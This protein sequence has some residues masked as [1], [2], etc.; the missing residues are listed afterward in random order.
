MITKDM[1]IESIFS[2]FPGKSQK[3]AQAI[4]A[5]GL[6]CVGCQ[7]S[8]WETLEAGMLGHGF[9]DQDVESLLAKLNSI[10]SEKEDLSSISM[11]E[12]AVKKFQEILKDDGREKTGLRFGIRAG[13][14]SGFEYTLD[15]SEEAQ[16]DDVVF[17]SFDQEIH[18]HES[19]VE[20][21]LGSNIDYVEGLH[22]AGFKIS[23]PNAKSSCGCG[24]S[25]NY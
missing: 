7:A 5:A 2:T 9:Q 8:T 23:N 25:Q 20:K 11:T 17:T 22:G 24:K 6:N 21:L 12:R 19:M 4:Q 3:L 13:G 14:C 16:S 18:V 10:L 15:Y 1:T